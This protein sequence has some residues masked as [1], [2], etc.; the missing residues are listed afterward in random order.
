MDDWMPNLRDCPFCGENPASAYTEAWRVFRSED[1]PSPNAPDERCPKYL[2]VICGNCEAKG[3]DVRTGYLILQ[4]AAEHIAASW[5]KRLGHTDR[6][7]NLMARLRQYYSAEKAM[8][9]LNTPH[10][11][12]SGQTALWVWSDG[13]AGEVHAILDRLDADAFI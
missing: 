10:P 8:E 11:Q 3:P 4:D 2:R 7:A 1:G 13:R 12:L 6:E 5:N 9:W